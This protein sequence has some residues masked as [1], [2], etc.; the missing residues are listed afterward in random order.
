M[1]SMRTTCLINNFN[2]KDYVCEAIDSALAQTHSFDEIIV[3]DDASTDDSIAVLQELYGGNANV[4]II[5]HEENQG[6]LAAVTTGFLHSTGDIIFFLDSDD[7]YHPQYLEIALNI[8]KEYP[9][10]GFLHC[11]MGIF[12]KS[13]NNYQG[14]SQLQINEYR[15]S[16][17]DCG[18]SII[19]TLE[20]QAFVGSPNSGN[21]IRRKYLNEILP[22]TCVG[23]YRMTADCCYVLASSLLGVRKFLINL[24]L[25]AYRMRGKNMWLG[26]GNNSFNKKSV[27]FYEEQI[28]VSR[29]IKF[30]S[31]KMSYSRH[32][33]IRLA[34]FEFKTADPT[35]D[36]FFDY[37]K[38]MLNSSLSVPSSSRWQWSKLHGL[39]I[40]LKHM[41]TRR[42]YHN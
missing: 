22:C 24:P 18:C 31:N 3:V 28:A 27:G 9:N 29:L 11:Q 26:M 14:P 38:I 42:K 13:K 32:Q 8:Y 10:Y 5:V 21:S 7:F 34:P 2:Y 33:L 6:L 36:L 4:K 20:N 16:L 30:Y 12:N 39:R 19:I 35:W 17:R 15:N 1:E 37:L 23:N 25:V 40:M 41:L